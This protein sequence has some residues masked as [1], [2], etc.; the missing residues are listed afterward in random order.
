MSEN[1]VFRKPWILYLIWLGLFL[2]FIFIGIP[3]LDKGHSGGEQIPLISLGYALNVLI[4][5]TIIISA[6]IPFLYNAWFRKYW[7]VNATIGIL[8]IILLLYVEVFNK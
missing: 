1:S 8:C 2:L 3:L 4:Y 5:G 6:V 7:Y